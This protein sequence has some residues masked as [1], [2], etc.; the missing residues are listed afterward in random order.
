MAVA[1]QL[2]IVRLDVRLVGETTEA[3]HQGELGGADVGL[4]ALLRGDPVDLAY[5]GVG[6]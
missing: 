2:A 5:G 6:V 1:V 4:V 3:V